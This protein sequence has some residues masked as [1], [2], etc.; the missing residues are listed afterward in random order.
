MLSYLPFSIKALVKLGVKMT[1]RPGECTHLLAR[2]V[3]RTEK[4][5]CALASSPY[6]LSEK[7][8]LASA[9]TKR[10]LRMFFIAPCAFYGA[11]PLIPNS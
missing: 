7:W 4:F 9:E 10:L 2:Q 3:V 11:D 6:I 5:L 8:A 1:T